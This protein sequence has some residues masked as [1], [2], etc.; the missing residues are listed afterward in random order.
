MENYY[1][2]HKNEDNNLVYSCFHTKEEYSK[3]ITILKDKNEFYKTVTLKELVLLSPKFLSC[4]EII[5]S[6]IKINMIKA[7]DIHRATL[8]SQRNIK[9]SIL[10]VSYMRAME[11]GD[12]DA[13]KEIAAQKQAL[14]DIPAHPAIEAAQTPDELIELTLEKLLSL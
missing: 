6:E 3:K 5:N 4:W 7:R 9:L 13:M 12:A 10:D 8:R 11:K 1:I 2:I 14:R